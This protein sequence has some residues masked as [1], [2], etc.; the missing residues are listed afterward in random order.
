[1]K[2]RYKAV[3]FDYDGTLV[4]TNQLI[5]D[6]WDHMYQ[7]HFGG[8]LTGDDVKWTFGMVLW[9]AIDDYM[10]QL[11]H[12]GYDL[13]ELVESYR[14]FQRQPDAT[15]APP[16]E[17]MVEAVRKLKEEGVLLGIVTSRGYD[18]CVKGLKKYGMADCFDAFVTAESTDI[19]KPQPEPALICCRELG[20]DPAVRY[21]V[22]RHWRG[23]RHKGRQADLRGEHARGDG[24]A[25]DSGSIAG[26]VYRS[27]GIRRVI[28]W[29]IVCF[30]G[31][32]PH[33]ERR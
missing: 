8:H 7:K 30:A 16:F 6:S 32:R 24:G 11:G 12:S 33:S 26:I 25:A 15:P 2:K 21:L 9:D 18:T 1:M 20:V 31:K 27:Y 13:Q 29:Q 17:G 10:K 23:R 5:V 3:L 4:D 28:T 14:E 19:H 22:L